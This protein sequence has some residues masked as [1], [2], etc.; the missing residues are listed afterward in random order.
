[1]KKMTLFILAFAC[2]ALCQERPK[3]LH[4]ST[5]PSYTDI[6]IDQLQPNHK[7]NPQAT[8]PE[9]ISVT[10]ENS[11]NNI[12]LI[13]L[14]K[15]GFADTTIRVTLSEKD[16][17]YLIVSLRPTYDNEMQEAQEKILKKRYNKNFGRMMMLGSV[18]PFATS[19]ISAIITN[20]FINS[21][22]EEKH[23]IENSPLGS[24]KSIQTH[25]KN[26]KDYND[27][28]S[29]GKIVFNT[30]ISLGASLLAVGVILQF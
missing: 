15:P 7:S 10:K 19:A 27:K 16:T 2:L 9:F 23:K 3:Y 22:N 6:Y 4:V 21:A 14:F 28:A 13:S 12:I 29:I 8:S 30:G 11:N 26:F 20:S 1:M 17:S 24:D 5:I 25:E 18:I